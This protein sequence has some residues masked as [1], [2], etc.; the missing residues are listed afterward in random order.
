MGRTSPPLQ[1]FVEALAHLCCP[2]FF[3]DNLLHQPII[4]TKRRFE[5]QLAGAE[6]NAAKEVKKPLWQM[7]SG[8]FVPVFQ[9]IAD[10]ILNLQGDP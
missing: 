1:L 8:F 7:L 10:L 3:I 6:I 4:I 9:A 5:T 2:L